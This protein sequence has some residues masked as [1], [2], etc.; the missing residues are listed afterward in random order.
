[1]SCL[2]SNIAVKHPYMKQSVAALLWE[3][4]TEISSFSFLS[5]TNA[6]DHCYSLTVAHYWDCTCLFPLIETDCLRRKIFGPQSGP[7]LF[8]RIVVTMD[9]ETPDPMFI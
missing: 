9:E 4:Q 1:M 8:E 7:S 5:K 3:F 2:T 6:M